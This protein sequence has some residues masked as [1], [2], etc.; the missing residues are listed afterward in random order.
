MAITLL[1]MLLNAKMVTPAQIDDALQNRVF[2]GGKIGTSL[3]ELGFLREEDLAQFLGRKL[4]V[5]YIAPEALLHIPA[6]T[7]ALIPAEMALKYRVIPLELKQ[8]RLSLVMSDPADLAAVDEISF[9]TGYVI[10]PMI[11]PEF[12]LLQ[13]LNLYYGLQISTRFQQIIDRLHTETVATSWVEPVKAV[14]PPVEDA[15]AVLAPESE[16]DDAI[17][18]DLD[19]VEE[20]E[21]VEDEVWRPIDAAAAGLA[22]APDNPPA[23]DAWAEKVQHYA[24][25]EI[26]RRLAYVEDREEIA[27]A[28]LESLSSEFGRAALFIVRGD[29]ASGWRALQAGVDIPDFEKV[30]IPFARPSV[31]KTVAEGKSFY[32]GPLTTNPLNQRILA[33]LGGTPSASALVMPVV[34]FGRVVDI[35]YLEGGEGD[36]ADSLPEVQRLLNKA[37]LAFEIL[38]CRDK[39]LLG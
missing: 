29:N 38:I 28:V 17:V 34:V 12:R 30:H 3:V 10:K 25:G 11:A 16:I 15:P 37:A 23:E 24:V 2:F 18:V 19:E 8:R 35:L 36:L 4:M 6:E 20:L 22:P 13:A 39:I 32:L 1:D 27:A 33:A 26:S 14:A 5:P 7:I 21:D 9:I 31:L